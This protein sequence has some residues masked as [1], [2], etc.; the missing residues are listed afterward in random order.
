MAHKPEGQRLEEALELCLALADLVREVDASPRLRQYHQDS[1][2]GD[3]QRELLKII[4]RNKLDFVKSDKLTKGGA[5][6]HIQ[7]K[8]EKAPETKW[9]KEVIAEFWNANDDLTKPNTR[10]EQA[11]MIVERVIGDN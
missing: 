3:E 11:R 9:F 2:P 8:L 4:F 5:I 1:L 10:K 6:K 7:N